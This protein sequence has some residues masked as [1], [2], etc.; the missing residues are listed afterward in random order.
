MVEYLLFVRYMQTNQAN[1]EP[2]RKNP[3]E[4]KTGDEP[5]TA[6]QRSYLDT[7]AQDVGEEIK[8]DLTKAEASKLIDD[9]Q[10]RSPRLH[11]E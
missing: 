3:D 1:P 9:L 2:L 5:A 8:E 10:Q 6:A 4:W 11:D 7:L